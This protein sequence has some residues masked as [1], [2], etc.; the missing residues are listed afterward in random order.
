MI[1]KLI[2]PKSFKRQEVPGRQIVWDSG[3]PS[4]WDKYHKLT[5]TNPSLDKVWIVRMWNIPI[6]D[7]RPRSTDYCTGVSDV[8]ESPINL[9]VNLIET[10][11]FY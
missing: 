1:M 11:G 3:D 5:G 9:M 6:L 7:G 4:G 10:S 2:I 8:R